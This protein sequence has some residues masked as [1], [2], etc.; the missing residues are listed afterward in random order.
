MD[1]Q[2]KE[3]HDPH[4]KKAHTRPDVARGRQFERRSGTGR[5]ET[6]KKG[7]AGKANWGNEL[8]V[9]ARRG[10]V[11]LVCIRMRSIIAGLCMKSKAWLQEC[12]SPRKV[13]GGWRL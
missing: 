7:G 1:Q 4:D 3:I 13:C 8:E 2:G 11:P 12:S 5:E 9:R 10:Y 6:Q